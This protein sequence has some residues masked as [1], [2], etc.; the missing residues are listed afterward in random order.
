MLV[1]KQTCKQACKRALKHASEHATSKHASKQADKETSKQA[2]TFC[3]SLLTPLKWKQEIS[4]KN[5]I[6][7]CD[8]PLVPVPIVLNFP[9]GALL[10]NRFLELPD[11]CSGM[12]TLLCH[13][14]F[15]ICKFHQLGDTLRTHKNREILPVLLW[16]ISSKTEYRSLMASTRVKRMYHS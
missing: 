10:R 14:L 9:P 16:N 11:W 8:R 15:G 13:W 5:F 12:G 2:L 3:S 7:K 4:W 1:C 6:F